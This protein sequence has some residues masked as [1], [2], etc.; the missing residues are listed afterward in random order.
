MHE[1]F[2]IRQGGHSIRSMPGNS[3]RSTSSC[4]LDGK[5][6]QAHQRESLGSEVA[7]PLARSPAAQAQLQSFR[8]RPAT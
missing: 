8:R 1:D 4:Q 3:N 5:L 7:C 2:D 6:R